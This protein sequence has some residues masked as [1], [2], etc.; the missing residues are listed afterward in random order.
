MIFL[1]D[2]ISYGSRELIV[3]H[4]IDIH[5]IMF[6]FEVLEVNFVSN[7]RWLMGHVRSSFA[8]PI[9]LMEKSAK[10][11]PILPSTRYTYTIDTG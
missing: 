7:Y 8:T 6:T 11:W 5:F 3:T 10:F 2:V 9:F 1:N 4:S